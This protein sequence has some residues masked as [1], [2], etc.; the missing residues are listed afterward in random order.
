MDSSMFDGGDGLVRVD[1][2]DARKA[3]SR[4]QKT[5]NRLTREIEHQ[6]RLLAEWQAF[7]QS[8]ASRVAK[9]LSPLE[10][11]I[12]EQRRALLKCFDA[13]HDGGK[14]TRR[15][16]GKMARIICT[17]AAEMLAG[18]R[19][20]E[21]VALHDKY[22]DISYD[23]LRK[24]ELEALK[25]MT[26]A[27]FGM[28]FDDEIRS[29]DELID[30]VHRRIGA[31]FEEAGSRE[32]DTAGM[33]DRWAGGEQAGRD[34]P[35]SV[36]ASA[37]LERERAAI[38]GATRSVR[39]VYRKLASELH[40]DR[41]SDPIERDRKTALMQRVNQAYD[42]RDLLQLLALQIEVEQIDPEHLASI[43]DDRLAH[44][45]R[46][47][48]DQAAELDQEIQDLV[49]PFAMSLGGRVYPDLTPSIVIGALQRDVAELRRES[50]WTAKQL[51]AFRDLRMLKAWLS[52]QRIERAPSPDRLDSFENLM[53]G[54]AE[55]TGYP[56]DAPIRSGKRRKPARR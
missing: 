41:E 7:A 44:Y 42:S 28:S 27:T 29:P 33:S 11:R 24:G 31:G 47:L 36:R 46:V 16:Q 15:E 30:A 40:P 17:R 35:A 32:P 45:N 19:D 52:T 26:E 18:E 39:E 43:G 50:V 2:V 34:K 8:F 21:L 4:A 51:D 13:A 1:V 55:D 49:E 14:L 56:E 23:D 25:A 38:E 37:R 12:D 3:L 48:K 5:F 22:S 10:R 9:E 20:P 54:R 53:A 6:R